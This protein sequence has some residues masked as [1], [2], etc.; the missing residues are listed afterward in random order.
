M[1]QV[2]CKLIYRYTTPDSVFPTK[3]LS[4]DIIHPFHTNIWI[5]MF[6]ECRY[7]QQRANTFWSEQ[8]WNCIEIYSYGL[9]YHTCVFELRD[10]PREFVA[11]YIYTHSFQSSCY[12]LHQS[13]TTLITHFFGLYIM[14][15][16]NANMNFVHSSTLCRLRVRYLN[17]QKAYY[18]ESQQSEPHFRNV[19]WFFTSLARKLWTTERR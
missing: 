9:F 15:V 6:G 10:G 18:H 16:S 14:E 12:Y 17:F 7:L 3:K 5:I 11:I 2:L 4:I 19:R 13:C 8:E 1:I